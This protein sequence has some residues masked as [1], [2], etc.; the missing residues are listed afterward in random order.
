MILGGGF[1]QFFLVLV[2]S[3]TVLSST[4][5]IVTFFGGLEIAN[6]DRFVKDVMPPCSIACVFAVPGPV[7]R[8]DVKIIDGATLHI[9]ESRLEGLRANL[10][11]RRREIFACNA[12][13]LLL[14]SQQTDEDDLGPVEPETLENYLQGAENIGITL[15]QPL[16]ILSF[17]TWYSA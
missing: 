1:K 5:V 16:W 15:P 12:G 2:L 3:S 4:P 10:K 8:P 13:A 11:L 17:S 7:F 6:Q 14:A 9:D